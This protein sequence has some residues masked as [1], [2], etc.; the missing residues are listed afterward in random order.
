MVASFS[1]G[2]NY[3]YTGD[4]TIDTLITTP[5]GSATST[6]AFGVTLTNNVATQN[7]LG[8]DIL[9]NIA[10]LVASATSATVQLG[11]GNASPPSTDSVTPSFSTATPEI[12]YCSAIVPNN[13]YVIINTTGTI[14]I[15]SITCQA[16]QL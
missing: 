16:C 2:G 4:T 7:T 12:V 1:V 11:V 5:V 6:G 15:T 8:Y 9:L 14:S 10:V 13:Y 3:T